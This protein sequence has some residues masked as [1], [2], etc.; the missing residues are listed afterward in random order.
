MTTATSC[1][2]IAEILVERRQ[3]L[4]EVSQVIRKLTSRGLRAHFVYVRVP[5]ADIGERHFQPDVGFD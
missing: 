5:A 2:P 3:G 4:A 1:H